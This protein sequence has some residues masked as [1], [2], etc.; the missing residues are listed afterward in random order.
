MALRYFLF[1]VFYS[2]WGWF[3]KLSLLGSAFFLVVVSAAV[4]PSFLQ[5]QRNRFVMGICLGFYLVQVIFTTAWFCL[6]QCL[7]FFIPL[8]TGSEEAYWNH[9]VGLSRCRSVCLSILESPCWPIPLSF[10]LSVHTG[11]TMLA[12]P[13]VILS[14]LESPCWPVPLSFCLSI[15]ESLCW[16]VPL[17]FCLSMCLGFCHVASEP[18]KL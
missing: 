2:F 3:V 4:P 15:L 11:I 6:C 1:C 13:A 5:W 17:L 8:I 16:P 7:G 10:C 14:I 12:Y 9:H 18:L